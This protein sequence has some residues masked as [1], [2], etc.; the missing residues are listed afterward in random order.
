[1]GKLAD[2]TDGDQPGISGPD[3]GGLPPHL[4]TPPD[5]GSGTGTGHQAHWTIEGLSLATKKRAAWVSART[6]ATWTEVR[7][8]LA[9]RRPRSRACV[10]SQETTRADLGELELSTPSGPPP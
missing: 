9:D 1:M 10:D 6:A 5:H 7:R 3:E 2:V 4:R 8:L